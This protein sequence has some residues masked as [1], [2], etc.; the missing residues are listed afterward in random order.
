MVD[1]ALAFQQGGTATFRFKLGSGVDADRHVI[2]LARE[3]L[4]P[5]AR[6]RVDYNQAYTPGE[7]VQAIAAIAPFGDRLRRA[8]GA[9]R[10]LARAWRACSAR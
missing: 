1:M 10:R 9:R 2:G 7:A 4:G 3:A 5:A 8:T 6:M